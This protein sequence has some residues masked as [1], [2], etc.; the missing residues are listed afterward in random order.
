MIWPLPFVVV[1]WVEL[2]ASKEPFGRH[3]RV[4]RTGDGSR[5]RHGLVRERVSELILDR[6]RDATA[7]TPL[8][9]T[10]DGD[11]VMEEAEADAVG[12]WKVTWV[13]SVMARLLSEVSTALNVTVSAVG[14]LT[15]KLATPSDPVVS[16]RA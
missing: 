13:V 10:A 11:T 7:V 14:S 6:H 15:V 9:G 8:A 4:R 12:T 2:E 1:I 16:S 5:D 3:R